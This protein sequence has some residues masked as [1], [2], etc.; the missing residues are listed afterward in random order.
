[1]GSSALAPDWSLQDPVAYRA[2]YYAISVAVETHDWKALRWATDKLDEI[3]KEG[4]AVQCLL[5]VVAS[6]ADKVALMPPQPPPPP[7]ALPAGKPPLPLLP[8]APAEPGS[9]S[10]ALVMAAA[11]D[12]DENI[13]VSPSAVAVEASAEMPVQN[14]GSALAKADHEDPGQESRESFMDLLSD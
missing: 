12:D 2:L 6:A 8:D 13:E 14:V 7:P 4:R 10:A 9:G 11:K 5:E 1:M 3:E